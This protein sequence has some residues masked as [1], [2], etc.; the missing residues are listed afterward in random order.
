MNRKL[1]VEELKRLSE[2]EFKEAPKREIQLILNNIRSLNNIG[3]IFRT[4]DA[5]RVEM[6]HL[7]GITASP[8]HRD[9]TKTALGSTESVDWRYTKN[10][11]DIISELKHLGYQ[12]WSVEQT[13][14][15]VSLEEFNV[16]GKIALI[17]G[18]EVKGVDQNVIDQ[19]NGSVEIP[20]F[21]S[22][23]SLNV[24]NSAAILMWELTRR[25]IVKGDYLS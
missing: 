7:C 6:I 24:A 11:Q 18:N 25:S 15:S 1:K 12:I 23:H 16:D 10:I 14:K 22:K 8:P 17:L 20:Q 9:I 21:G 19:S 13:T 4:A 2:K 3:S 5:F